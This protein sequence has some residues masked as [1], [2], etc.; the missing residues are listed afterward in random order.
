MAAGSSVLLLSGLTITETAAATSE[1]A[2]EPGAVEILPPDELVGGATLGEWNAQWWQWALS[3]S[4]GFA[5]EQGQHGAVFFMPPRI[6]SPW[7]C[8]VPEGTPIYLLV[9]SGLCSTNALPP[10]FGH[11]EEELQTCVDSPGGIFE[12]P[13]PTTTVTLNGQEITDLDVYRATSPTFMLNVSDYAGQF[14]PAGVSLAMSVSWGFIIAPP[15]GDVTLS[16]NDDSREIDFTVNFTV[17]APEITEPT[18][19][20]EPPASEAAVVTQP[21]STT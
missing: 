21:P 14:F 4:E 7:D 17:T 11:N 3:Q 20:E 8:V 15:T 13:P 5:C 6:A 1:P 2:P 16:V 12:G 19:T 9:D 10:N 18:N